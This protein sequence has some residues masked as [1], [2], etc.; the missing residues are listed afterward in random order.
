MIDFTTTSSYK[1]LVEY[2][3]KLCA[4][5]N[6]DINTYY[7]AKNT[8]NHIRSLNG[9]KEGKYKIGS[10]D[11]KILEKLFEYDTKKSMKF[12]TIKDRIIYIRRKKWDNV[13]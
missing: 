13:F 2:I 10:D 3:L 1:A 12:S 4:Y 7:I 11:N 6:L 5:N 9:Y 8:L